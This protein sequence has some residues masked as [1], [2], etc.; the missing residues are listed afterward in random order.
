[1]A[2][3]NG[4]PVLDDFQRENEGPPPS[5]DWVAGVYVSSS[6]GADLRV[7]DGALAAGTKEDKFEGA[8]WNTSF[9]A[10]L[11]SWV[12]VGDTGREYLLV[13]ACVSSPNSDGDTCGYQL[14]YDYSSS[15]DTIYLQRVDNDVETELGDW[16]QEL[17]AGD[18]LSLSVIDGVVAVHYRPADGEWTVLGS[19]EDSTYTSGFNAVSIRNPDSNESIT[20]TEFGGGEITEPEPPDDQK[21]QVIGKKHTRIRFIPAIL[22][23]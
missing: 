22:T 12:T 20:V 23:A 5:D 8:Y 4:T 19:V 13:W 2:G 6:A 10:P 14:G 11:E 21:F 1:M 9:T 17:D 16:E 7:I 15:T 18:A 3:P